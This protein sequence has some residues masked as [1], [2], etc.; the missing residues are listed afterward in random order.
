MLTYVVVLLV[1]IAVL[2]GS[3][4]ALGGADPVPAEDYRMVLGRLTDLTSERVAELRAALGGSRP[5]PVGTATGT[6][7]P[8]ADPLVERAG[9]L[10]RKLTGYR[11]QLDRLE[12]SAAG[13]E[14]DVLTSAR[15]LLTAAVEDHAWACRL[16]EG[17]SYHENP[18]IQDAVAA[19]RDH[20]GRCLEAAAE[21]LTDRAAG[22]LS[23]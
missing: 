1:V 21:V 16:V 19:L 13:D 20:G 23:V 3:Y 10:R 9:E 7:R 8:A 22:S 5:A 17:G 6:S 4:R 15:T 18:G 14:L 12:V 2:Y 11:Q